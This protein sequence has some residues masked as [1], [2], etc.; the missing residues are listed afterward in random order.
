[1]RRNQATTDSRRGRWE[2]LSS[3]LDSVEM[4]SASALSTET[5]REL[6]ALYRAT[7]SDLLEEVRRD[8]DSATAEYLRGLVG[9]GHGLLHRGTSPRIGAAI[10]RFF[11]R[12]FPDVVR[13]RFRAVLLVTLIFF[14]GA[15]YGA[16]A[17]SADTGAGEVLLPFGHRYNDPRARV[18]QEESGGTSV[19]TSA[20]VGT[21]FAAQLMTH[22]SQVTYLAFA[23]AVTGGIGTVL[24]IFANGAYLGAVGADYVAAGEGKFFVAWVGPHGVIEIPAMLLGAAAG[25]IL[26]RALFAPGLLGRAR[27]LELAGKD[28]LHLL[29]GATATLVLAGII[30][31]TFSQI[32]EPQISYD[33]KIAFAAVLLALYLFY[34][35]GWSPELLRRF[36][37]RPA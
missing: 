23:L 18:A 4:R 11:A 27:A 24:M 2:R 13:R 19:G 12:D 31:G 14:A 30:E 22:N 8:A 36:R 28:A 16:V 26:A 9:R 20:M 1:M 3:L 5:A 32:H 29:L 37:R 21:T 25:L 7:S 33:V 34:L 10:A 15:T 17:M 6:A 35:F